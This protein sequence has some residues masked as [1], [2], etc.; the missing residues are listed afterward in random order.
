L[1]VQRLAV[2]LSVEQR[3]K[4]QAEIEKTRSQQARVVWFPS[5]ALVLQRPAAHRCS[6]PHPLLLVGAGEDRGA[7]GITIVAERIADVEGQ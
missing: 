3:L 2:L 7:C 5:G 6:W 1:F 4:R